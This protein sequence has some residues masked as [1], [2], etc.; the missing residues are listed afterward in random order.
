MNR[1][2]H[3]WRILPAETR[4]W[5]NVVVTEKCWLWIA[6]KNSDG[7]GEITVDGEKLLAHQFSLRIFGIKVPKG[8]ERD[9]LCRNPACVH[10]KHI[11]PVTQKVNLLRGISI[12]AQNAR[13]QM[14]KNGHDLQGTNLYIEVDSRGRR[15]RR[16]RVC[17]QVTG[18]EFRSRHA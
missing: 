7:Y 17:R 4:F 14:C 12:P 15:H 1:Q 8:F 10:P 13:K 5:A 18:Q 6:G 16:C 9:H 11:E 3:A 2:S